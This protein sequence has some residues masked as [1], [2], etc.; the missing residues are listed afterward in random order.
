LKTN[1]LKKLCPLSLDQ[2]IYQFK[3]A[4]KLKGL[5]ASLVS[6]LHTIANGIDHFREGLH[7]HEISGQW[8]DILGGIVGQPR[9]GI[10]YEEY[11]KWLKIRIKLNRCN[12]TPEEIITIIRLLCGPAYPLKITEYKI[13]D[14]VFNFFAPLNTSPAAVFSLIKKA[15]PPGLKHHF[16]DATQEKPFQLDETPFLKSQF[17]DFFQEDFIHDRIKMG[18]QPRS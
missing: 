5:I 7:I 11:R 9:S 2:Y 15:S 3:E 12:G 17:A 8:L 6:P 1:L 10:S 14:I 16:V 18:H 13:N 4:K